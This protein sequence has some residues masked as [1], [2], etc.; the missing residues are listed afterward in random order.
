MSNIQA[1]TETFVDAVQEVSDRLQEL[2]DT[3]GQAI[4]KATIRDLAYK[5]RKAHEQFKPK[6]F[7]AVNLG[8]GYLDGSTAEVELM[9]DGKVFGWL[10]FNGPH[11]AI[12]V[13]ALNAFE[14]T[15]KRNIE[16]NL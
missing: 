16:D 1:N 14:E 10:C 3:A 13:D 5:L 12:V 6:A 8:G 9:H 15:E 7:T 2:V 4:T 11:T